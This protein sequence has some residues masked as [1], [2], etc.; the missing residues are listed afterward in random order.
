MKFSMRPGAQAAAALAIRDEVAVQAID[1]VE[2]VTTLQAQGVKGL[3]GD[4]C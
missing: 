3:G 1:H 2:L 4:R